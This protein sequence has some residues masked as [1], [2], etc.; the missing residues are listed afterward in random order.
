MKTVL[1]PR[2]GR[3]PPAAGGGTDSVSCPV[4]TLRRFIFH[5]DVVM[6]CRQRDLGSLLI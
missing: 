6:D 1:P 5:S 4:H 3:G 2:A